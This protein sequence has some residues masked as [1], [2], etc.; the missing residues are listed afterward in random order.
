MVAPVIQLLDPHVVNQIAAG[1]VVDRPASVVKELVENALD[2]GATRVEVRVEEGGKALIE[3]ADD[4]WGMG[5][6]DLERAFLPHATSKVSAVE[7]LTHVGTLGFRGEALASIGSVSRAR[8]VSRPRDADAGH[9]IDDNEGEVSPVAP[10][11]ASP[12]TVVRV[13]NLF[14]HVP[15]RRKFL[16]TPGTEMGHINDLMGRFALAFPHVAFRL[17]QGKR[18]LLECAAGTSR[19]ER[20]DHVYGADIAAQLLTVNDASGEPTLEAYIGPP[21]LTRRDG[22]LEQVFLNGRHVRDRTVMHAI[23]EAYRDLVP[24]G[25]HRPVAFVFLSCDPALVDVNVHPAKAEVRWRDGS[26]AHRVVRR[27][28]RHA[29]ERA[30]PGKAIDVHDHHAATERAVAFAFEQGRGRAVGTDAFVRSAVHESTPAFRATSE[31]EP[32]AS[33]EPAVDAGTGPLRPLAQALGTYLVLESEDAIVLVD[34]HA[35][36]ERVLFDEINT[37]LREKGNL[38]GAALADADR[39]ERGERGD[40]RAERRSGALGDARLG[41]RALRRGCR[42]RSGGAGGASS[43]RSGGGVARHPRR[44]RDRAARRPGP[45]GA[46]ERDRRQSRLPLGRHGRRPLAPRRGDGAARA[47]RGAGSQPLVPARSAYAAHTLARPSRALVP[48]NRVTTG[49]SDP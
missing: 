25:G 10:A 3:V 19:L 11:A 17:T 37:R 43:S 21:T 28:L 46:V 4:G 39:L 14:G 47:C 12:G 40:G 34:Q 9:R 1:E 5:P 27:A 41:G 32:C 26:S 35:L 22:R 16:R 7:D 15:A 38:E 29:L 24:P 18:V 2:A 36:H 42:R 6:Q 23:R 13:E 45:H 44:A 33:D 20:I 49:A 31:N 48:S 30:A 8:I